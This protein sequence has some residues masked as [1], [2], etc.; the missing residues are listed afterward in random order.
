MLIGGLTTLY[1]VINFSTNTEAG[2]INESSVT[3]EVKKLAK[4]NAL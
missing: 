1:E 2:T 3:N 4:A